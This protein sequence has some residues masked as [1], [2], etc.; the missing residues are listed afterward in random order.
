MTTKDPFLEL[1]HTVSNFNFVANKVDNK[2]D[3]LIL[4]M[5]ETEQQHDQVLKDLGQEI[6]D[7]KKSQELLKKDFT[8]TIMKFCAT[9]ESDYDYLIIQDEEVLERG[10]KIDDEIFLVTQ[11]IKRLYEKEVTLIMERKELAHKVCNAFPGEKG[12]VEKSHIYDNINVTS[13]DKKRKINETSNSHGCKRLKKESHDF[14]TWSLTIVMMKMYGFTLD[15]AKK[16]EEVIRNLKEAFCFASK[17]HRY[18]TKK[19]FIN[20]VL[21]EKKS[22]LEGLLQALKVIKKSSEIDEEVCEAKELIM[23]WLYQIE[24]EIFF[25]VNDLHFLMSTC[26]DK[27]AEAKFRAHFRSKLAR[28]KRRKHGRVP[29]VVYRILALL[30]GKM[31]G[32]ERGIGRYKDENE[33]EMLFNVGDVMNRLY[34]MILCLTSVL[35]DNSTPSNSGMS[36][37]EELL[38][39]AEIVERCDEEWRAIRMKIDESLG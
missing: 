3:D 36:K 31:E 1:G 33:K 26:G 30:E 19:N 18:L 28:L 21:G 16:E 10:A 15:R 35:N 7:L 14:R 4:L 27:E 29:V 17:R 39:Y 24:R 32:K 6:N 9:D 23:E 38:A 2:I 11:E 5:K 13:S 8:Q 20:E 37:K 12:C 22:K 25:L 34:K